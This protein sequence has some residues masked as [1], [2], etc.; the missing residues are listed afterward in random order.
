MGVHYGPRVFTPRFY[1][2]ELWLDASD[3]TSFALSTDTVVTW[4]DKSGQARHATGVSNPKL[5]TNVQNGKS[6]VRCD[7]V[8][9]FNAD[10]NFT[11]NGSHSAYV[12]IKNSTYSNI[13]GAATGN[14]ANASLH[15]GFYTTTQYRMNFWSHDYY[16][17][18]TAFYK[19]GS[20][21]LIGFS[22]PVGDSKKVF[23]NGNLE[24]T[25]GQTALA[26]S[27][28]SGGGRILNVVGQ[29]TMAC[30][31][32][33]LVFYKREL[34]TTERQKI[35]GYLAHKWGI[36]ANLDATHTYK[37]SPPTA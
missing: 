36:T 12:V 23:A 9:Y 30:D 15:V 7:G 27:Y 33:E 26:P 16:P 11:A 17:S 34:T 3:A 28:P 13:Y 20:F 29:G 14:L 25:G 6:V 32:A 5:V 18:F 35:E 24:A 8:A 22:W 31:L 21:N 19:A 37:T 2:P 4:Y 1:Y 10:L